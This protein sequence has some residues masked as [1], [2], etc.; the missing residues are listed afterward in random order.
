NKKKEKIDFAE[1][2]VNFME[3]MEKKYLKR[4]ED[5]EADVRKLFDLKS[6]KVDCPNRKPLRKGKS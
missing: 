6:E 1:Q 2:A 5:L 3:K 4:I